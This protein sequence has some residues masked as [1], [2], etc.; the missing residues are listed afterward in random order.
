MSSVVSQ[1]RGQ[2]DPLFEAVIIALEAADNPLP[3]AFFTLLRIDLG[4]AE[5]E[6]EVLNVFFELSSTAFQG[7]VFSAAEAERVDAL[8][9]A[10]EG[11]SHAMTAE[12][13]RAH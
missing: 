8:L 9:A 11:I 2:I 10:C 12:D 13:G 6:S 1:I 3:L 5:D 7:F 4:N